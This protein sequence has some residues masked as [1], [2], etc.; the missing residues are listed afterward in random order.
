MNFP[1]HRHR[2][3]RECVAMPQFLR[4][5]SRRTLQPAIKILAGISVFIEMEWIGDWL[6]HGLPVK[7]GPAIFPGTSQ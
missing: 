6:D 3:L 2:L 4:A 5:L 7:N 1:R